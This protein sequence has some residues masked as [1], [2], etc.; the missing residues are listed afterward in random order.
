MQN[1][2]AGPMGGSGASGVPLQM[3]KFKMDKL[4]QDRI[5]PLV[6]AMRVWLCANKGELN[7]SLWDS[8]GCGNC[9]PTHKKQTGFVYGIYD[10]TNNCDC[11]NDNY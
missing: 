6:Q 11:S 2:P 4:L 10:D 9:E 1:N 3:I 5:D 7:L 8:R